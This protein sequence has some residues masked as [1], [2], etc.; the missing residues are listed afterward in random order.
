MSADVSPVDAAK[1]S[2]KCSAVGPTEFSALY[3]AYFAAIK[4]TFDAAQYAAVWTA[5]L[6]TDRA[7]KCATVNA[8]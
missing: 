6:A 4:S 2:A 7:T 8:A 3:A 1:Q 5:H